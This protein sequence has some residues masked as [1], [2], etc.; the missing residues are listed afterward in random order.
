[1]PRDGIEPSLLSEP[2]FESGAS[3]SST[4]EAT[5]R[6]YQNSH[7]PRLSYDENLFK[8]LHMLAAIDGNVSASQKCSLI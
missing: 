6:F 4:T 8:L 5:A 2:D 1:V 7:L 3:T